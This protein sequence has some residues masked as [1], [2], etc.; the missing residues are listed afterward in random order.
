MADNMR[1]EARSRVMS[2]IRARNTRPELYV[3]K[4][5][6]G[7]GFRYRLH[8]RRLPGVPDLTLKKYGIALFVHGCFWHQHDCSK[9]TMPA[10]N[11]EYWEPKL[12]GNASRDAR[13]KAQLKKL[14][15]EVLTIWECRLQADTERVINLLESLRSEQSRKLAGETI[16]AP[17]IADAATPRYMS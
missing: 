8:V 1:P 15:W 2:R 3:R 14:G 17:P 9:S 10:S 13:N 6:W 4:A 7:R 11:R 12:L 5:V 16:D